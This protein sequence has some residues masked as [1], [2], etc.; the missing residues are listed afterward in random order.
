MNYHRAGD[1]A[2]TCARIVIKAGRFHLAQN[3]EDLMEATGL[4]L[5]NLS[6]GGYVG[7]GKKNASARTVRK[8]HYRRAS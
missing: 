4:K 5:G 8:R 2:E 3:T 7:T 6:A 1:D